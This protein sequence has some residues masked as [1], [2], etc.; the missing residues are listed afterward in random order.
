MVFQ[1]SLS[2][3]PMSLSLSS[4]EQQ[5]QHRVFSPALSPDRYFVRRAKGARSLRSI[6]EAQFITLLDQVRAR[7]RVRVGSVCFCI[8]LILFSGR[9]SI[10]VLTL[11]VTGK[12]HFYWHYW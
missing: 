11:L 10:T 8:S 9:V 2:E 12:I 1:E 4:L 7:V 6:A 3:F 5:Q